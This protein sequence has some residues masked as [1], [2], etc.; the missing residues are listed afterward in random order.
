MG[1]L[2]IEALPLHHLNVVGR[3]HANSASSRMAT[4]RVHPA[5]AARILQGKHATMKPSA[6]NDSRLCSFSRWQ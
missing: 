5:D 4:A 6:G 1:F 3:L 2:E